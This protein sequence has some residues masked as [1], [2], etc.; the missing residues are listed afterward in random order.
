[1]SREKFLRGTYLGQI[2]SD[3]GIGNFNGAKRFG[4]GI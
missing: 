3:R 1:M 4:G 2:K